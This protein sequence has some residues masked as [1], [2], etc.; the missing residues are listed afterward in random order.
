MIDDEVTN[1]GGLVSSKSAGLMTRTSSLTQR[2]VQ[3]ANTILSLPEYGITP[4]TLSY[5]GVDGLAIPIIERHTPIPVQKVI[6]FPRGTIGKLPI[7]IHLVQGERPFAADNKTFGR[8]MLEGMPQGSR[9]VPEVEL[10]IGIDADAMLSVNAREKASGRELRVILKESGSGVSLGA[11]VERML[12]DATKHHEADQQRLSKLIGT[13]SG[14][15]PNIEGSNNLI[16][17]P[18]LVSCERCGH[19]RLDHIDPDSLGQDY[20]KCLAGG[21]DCSAYVPFGR[22]P[23]A[24]EMA[25]LPVCGFCNHAAGSH[26]F[27]AGPGICLVEDCTCGGYEIPGEIDYPP[28]PVPAEPPTLDP[29]PAE[30]APPP[31]CSWCNHTEEAHEPVKPD[32]TD[33]ECLVEGCRCGAY[34]PFVTNKDSEVAAEEVYLEESFPSGEELAA[35]AIQDHLDSL[36]RSEPGSPTPMTKEQFLQIMQNF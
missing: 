29:A 5:E 9:P 16:D 19:G 7:E 31:S 26:D 23:N 11:E 14:L 3:L 22:I 8:F 27:T 2:G 10:K 1:P 24:Q 15:E 28:E 33:R 20:G 18:M 25:A 35:G 4:L 34:E 12:M 13:R 21:C 30:A 17:G 36:S 32:G 6:T